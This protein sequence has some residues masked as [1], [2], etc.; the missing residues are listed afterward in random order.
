[1]GY[2]GPS[3]TEQERLT[4]ADVTTATAPTSGHNMPLRTV[5]RRTRPWE[6][7]FHSVTSHRELPEL[8]HGH[9]NGNGNGNGDNGL[10]HLEQLFA[11]NVG[12]LEPLQSGPVTFFDEQL[13]D[14]QR[15]AVA[16]AI[17]A[18]DCS[19]IQGLPGTGKS[20]VAA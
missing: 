5:A 16:S 3:M 7:I 19:L 18:P 20:R 9:H 4:T 6:L 14:T 1:M 17:H 15:K 11:G 8:G 12:H 13:D 10:S 2:R